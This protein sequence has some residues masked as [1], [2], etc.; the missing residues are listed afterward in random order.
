MRFFI[1]FWW[2][3]LHVNGDQCHR[4]RNGKMEW[5]CCN[6]HEE[7]NGICTECDVGYKAVDD[8][9]CKPCS[10]GTWGRK[11]RGICLIDCTSIQR[12]DRVVGCVNSTATT[13]QAE[14]VTVD[15]Y[16]TKVYLSIQNNTSQVGSKGSF[17]GGILPREMIIYTVGGGS[18]VIVVTICTMCL[19]YKES[20]KD[21]CMMYNVGNHSDNRNQQDEH[22]YDRVDEDNMRNTPMVL[23]NVN[24]ISKSSS[25]S[26][27]IVDLEDGYLEPHQPVVR[28][29]GYIEP[30]QPVVREY[31]D[32]NVINVMYEQ[33]ERFSESGS[34]TS[35]KSEEYL[36]PYQ[37]VIE[38]LNTHEYETRH[39]HRNSFDSLAENDIGYET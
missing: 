16:S 22:Y 14:G 25:E 37:P 4:T 29:D 30:N 35:H 31:N 17:N 26:D 18:F 2:M 3:C 28:D 5:F 38:N 9:P 15:S 21:R 34:N 6:N 36:N 20:I 32:T 13:T 24:R 7:K 1:L 19:C 23:R 11:C 33:R 39:H 10:P 27:N 8:L 12:C